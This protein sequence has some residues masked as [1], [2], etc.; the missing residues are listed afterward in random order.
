M[1]KFYAFEIATEG[2]YHLGA[3]ANEAERDRELQFLLQVLNELVATYA[4]GSAEGNDWENALDAIR[5]GDWEYT[6]VI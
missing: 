3:Y 5:M 1:S 6:Q 4:I 2:S